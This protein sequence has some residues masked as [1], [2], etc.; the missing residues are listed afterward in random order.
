M[1]RTFAILFAAALGFM[2]ATSCIEDEYDL[3][4]EIDKTIELKNFSVALNRTFTF[5]VQDILPSEYK[6]YSG[7]FVATLP[8]GVLGSFKVDGI[9]DELDDDYLFKQAIVTATIENGLPKPFTATAV[10][11]SKN[12]AVLDNIT[13]TL[14]SGPVPTGTSTITVASADRW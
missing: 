2:A 13:A 10:A 11:L 5:A 14:K 12:G 7:D 1:K 9:Y 4:K 3:D 6:N 8:D